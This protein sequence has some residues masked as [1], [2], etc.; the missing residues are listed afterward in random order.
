MVPEGAAAVSEKPTA[1]S[2]R[3]VTGRTDALWSDVPM[4]TQ[5]TGQRLVTA[6]LSWWPIY[7]PQSGHFKLAGV[8]RHLIHTQE[9]LQSIQEP[10]DHIISF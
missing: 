1:S 8:P 3:R 10:I 5:K 4:L 7:M 2:E 9:H 6:L